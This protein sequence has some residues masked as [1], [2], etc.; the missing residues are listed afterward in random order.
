MTR[1]QSEEAQR[2]LAL[3]R[4]ELIL[5]G[6]QMTPNRYTMYQ[7]P[8][9]NCELDKC[10]NY[11]VVRTKKSILKDEDSPLNIRTAV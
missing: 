3:I 2:L 1:A 9:E 4:P 10:L 7:I 8:S 6:I 5:C 11:D